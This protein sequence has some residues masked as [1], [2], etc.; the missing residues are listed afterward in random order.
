M[1]IISVDG[2]HCPVHELMDF[3]RSKRYSSKKYGKKAALAYEIAISLWTKKIVHT[4]GPHPAGAK[5]DYVIYISKLRDMIPAGKKAIADRIYSPE[6]APEQTIA[7]RNRLDPPDVKE[8]KRRARGRHEGLNRFVRWFLCMKVVW[9]HKYNKH[10]IFFDAVIVVIQYT[11]DFGDELFDILPD[12][13]DDSD[14]DDGTGGGNSSSDDNGE[15]EEEYD[16]EQHNDYAGE[17]DGSDGIDF[18]DEEEEEEVDGV[19]DDND[20][21]DERSTYSF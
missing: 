14:W 4:N 2:I 9:R 5:G 12:D 20:D 7:A 8:F 16:Y 13:D 6:S 11:L 10:V 17:E 15:E 18:F 21:M 19:D 3:E 1:H